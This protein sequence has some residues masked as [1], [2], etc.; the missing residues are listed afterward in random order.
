MKRGTWMLALLAAACTSSPRW[1]MHGASRDRT[2]ADARGCAMAAEAGGEQ[3]LS[4]AQ[5][6]DECM[7]HKGYSVRAG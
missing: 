2:E 1:E 3:G 5:L 4:E 7:R 6:V